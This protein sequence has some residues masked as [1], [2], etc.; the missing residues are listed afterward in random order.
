MGLVSLKTVLDL[1]QEGEFAIPAFNVY[2]METVMGV[3]QAAEE[4]QAPVIFQIYSRLFDSP[5]A[6]Y[7][8]ALIRQAATKLS[9]PVAFHLDHGAS[10]VQVTRALTS[11]CSGIMI[12]ASKLTLEENI[13]TT[14]S[15]VR[16]SGHVGVPVEGELGHVGSANDESM[17]QFTD[18]EEAAIFCQK[19]GVAALAIMVGTAHGR[20]RQAPQLDFECIAAIRR[21]TGVPLVLHGGSGVPDEQIRAAIDAGIRK[22]N[23]G[24]DLCYA[25]LDRIF[26]TKRDPVAIDIF[27]QGPIAAVKSFA[28]EKIKLTGAGRYV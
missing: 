14:K 11:G 1:A 25:F 10:I 7:L 8:A 13:A 17:A 6:S 19:T 21:K 4:L 3:A 5:G 9:V 12:D 15:V 22:V 27:M 24:T 23:F 20:Y 28:R 18:V 16:M 2:N 26:D